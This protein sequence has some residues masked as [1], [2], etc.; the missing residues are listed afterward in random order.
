MTGKPINRAQSPRLNRGRCK[1][2]MDRSAR[3]HTYLV[4]IKSQSVETN[5]DLKPGV[6][7]LT[8]SIN[9]ILTN[10]R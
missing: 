1:V 3:V 4:Y 10:T 8:Y 2:S 6:G 5:D 9:V 7:R